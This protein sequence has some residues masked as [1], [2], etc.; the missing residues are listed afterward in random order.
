MDRAKGIDIGNT[1]LNRMSAMEFSYAIAAVEVEK[2]R[3]L[4]SRTKFFSLMCDDVYNLEQ[5]I[6]YIRFSI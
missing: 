6:A 2:F 5:V 1:Y 3:E 4:F